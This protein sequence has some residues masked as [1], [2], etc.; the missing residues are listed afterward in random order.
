M[1]APS[2]SNRP[3]RGRGMRQTTRA[4]PKTHPTSVKKEDEDFKPPQKRKKT[5]EA[6]PNVKRQRLLKTANKF[7]KSAREKATIGWHKT[8][9]ML[10]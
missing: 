8:C 5:T 6:A 7:A 10:L 4:A 2:D 3:R 1:S 9:R